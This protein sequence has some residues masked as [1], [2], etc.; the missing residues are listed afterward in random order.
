[1]TA[2]ALLLEA[3]RLET[4]PVLKE[5]IEAL[6]EQLRYNSNYRE[7]LKNYL[8]ARSLSLS[9][10]ARATGFGR[11]F[12][13]DVI[14]GKRRLTAKSFPAFEKALKLPLSGRKYFRYL[15]ALAEP[16]IFP[17]LTPS[18]VER[19][20]QELRSKPWNR[21]YR[22]IQEKEDPSF[23][24]LLQDQDVMAVYAAAGS[25]ESGAT[26]EQILQRTRLSEGNL[27]KALK[28]LESVGLL[29]KT[30]DLYFPKDLHLFLMSSDKS[31][32]LTALFQK[33]AEKAQRRAP[34]GVSSATEF[35]F[36]SQFCV[37][38]KDLPALKL[39]LRETILKFVDEAIASEGDRI[40]KLVTALHL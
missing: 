21:P 18:Q 25:P 17:D 23:Q 4:K 1:M 27:E 10:F 22:Q 2:P 40:A 14:S 33:A 35:F 30:G 37:H 6:F 32:L 31:Q 15:V 26:R 5:P 13:G 3:F 36:T 39:A 19:A 8:E 11:G 38:E 28:R 34:T 20:L 12:P 16:D 29:T 24:F 7:F 9:D